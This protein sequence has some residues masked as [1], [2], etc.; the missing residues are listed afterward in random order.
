MQERKPFWRESYPPIFTNN[1]NSVMHNFTEKIC[2]SQ[3]ERSKIY[4]LHNN[5]AKAKN[6][7]EVFVVSRQR[8]KSSFFSVMRPRIRKQNLPMYVDR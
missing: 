8:V 6:D 1:A 3:I 2:K 7:N 4:E 5:D